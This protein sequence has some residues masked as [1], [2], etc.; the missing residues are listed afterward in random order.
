MQIIPFKEP[1]AWEAQIQLT[2]VIFLLKFK[3]N[4][5]NEYWVMSIFNRNDEPILLGVKVVVN[6]NLTGQF[7][8][9][10]MPSGDIICQNVLLG[11]EKIKRFDMG[12]VTEL[13]YYEEGELE[14]LEA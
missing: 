9:V 8:T 4:A 5:L 6:W 1:A 11:F 13:F 12:E 7:V 10:G 14:S 2:G 3:W